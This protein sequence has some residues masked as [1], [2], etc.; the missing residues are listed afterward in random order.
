ML[1]Q[2]KLGLQLLIHPCDPL[3]TAGV[4]VGVIPAPLA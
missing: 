4:G 2:L 3:G 1:E